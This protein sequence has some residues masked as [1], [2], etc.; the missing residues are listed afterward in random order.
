VHI[1]QVPKLARR[2]NGGKVDVQVPI[3]LLSFDDQVDDVVH[4]LLVSSR[5]RG[6]FGVFGGEE[7]ADGFDPEEFQIS[8]EVRKL[9][10]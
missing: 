4:S 2:V 10:G 8:V 1:S 3:V 7:V 6:V 9:I 5:L